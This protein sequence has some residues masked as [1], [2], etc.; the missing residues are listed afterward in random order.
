MK[1][2][3]VGRRQMLKGSAALLLAFSTGAGAEGP[4]RLTSGSSGSEFQPN[5]FL[6]IG[7]DGSIT[8]ILGPTE[9]GQGIHTALARVLAE[10]LDADWAA[11]R[12]EAAPV[13]PAYG[14]PLLNKLQATEAS[15]SMAGYYK[16]TR[17]AAA[18]AR[19]MLVEAAA[20]GWQVSVERCRTHASFV[21]CD[22]GRRAAYATLVDLAS[23]R[24]RPAAANLKLKPAGSFAL[25]G[26]SA[27]RTDIREQ[28]TGQVAYGVDFSVP[29]AL[30]AMV[31][32]A[33]C[34]GA[35]V[36]YYDPTVR[37]RPH[38]R[39][40]VVVPS[41]VAV[42][43]ENQWAAR[44]A[45]EKLAVQWDLPKSERYSTADL[46]ARYR[47]LSQSTG[48]AVIDKGKA[49]DLIAGGPRTSANYI[50]PYLTHAPME[51]LNCTIR[52]SINRT[53]VWTGTQ[54]QSF[55]HKLV[56]D[57]LA[58]PP[59]NVFLHT[60][61]MGG[62][63]GRRGSPN[64]DFVVETAEIIK[65]TRHIGAPI[66]NIWS[67]SD[68]FQGGFYRPMAA[69]QLDAVVDAA[70]FPIAWRHRI[71]SR[72]ILTGTHFD[73]F[74]I[75]GVD[76]TQIAGAK[77]LQYSVENLKVEIH[78]PTLGPTVMWMRSV[79]NSNT[80][81]AIES[82]VDELAL[83]ARKDP[84]AYRKT[85]LQNRGDGG[86][87]SRVMEAA[88]EKAGWGSTL[89][90]GRGRGLAVHDFWGTV[91]AQIAE[92]TLQDN[93]I[94]V[95]RVV[96]AID[97]G[98]IINPDGVRAQAEGGIIYGLSSALFGEITF[99]R[100]IPDQANFDS[101]PILR[102]DAS[103]TIDIVLIDSEAEPSGI[104]EVAVP[105]IAPAVCNAIVAA[106][107]K[108]IRRLPISGQGYSA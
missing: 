89:P 96:C 35:T 1:D 45:C 42:I 26:K 107:G 19:V 87:L 8:A 97:C 9:M 29:D 17:L 75:D 32:H 90:E 68:D 28:V 86:R 3:V 44:T 66:K 60:L 33:P 103:P 76:L 27:P 25:I 93:Q 91:V 30:I 81:F 56:C 41:G 105:P 70:G 4:R 10:E 85:L 14:N 48:R 84:V 59:S 13:G 50:I 67:R 57:A 23:R 80:A 36:R 12:V 82:F 40:V 65:A 39:D 47:A 62:G 95:D 53:D 52:D 55:Q 101:Y 106:G 92:V 6:R 43:A 15:V 24:D 34:P 94:R 21:I 31:A 102:M 77:D 108:R 79:G 38:V 98:R 71:A 61:P 88:A 49:D 99:T 18:A 100:G 2:M 74:V 16:S 51:P 46:E 64:G 11:I 63:F 54:D 69:N 37:S 20:A 7:A 73:F 58:R 104:G 78:N 22:D 72:S 5:A 83:Q